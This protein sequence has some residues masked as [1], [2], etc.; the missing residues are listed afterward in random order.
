MHKN[1]VVR[2]LLVGFLFLPTLA[3]HA[4]IFAHHDHPVC[5]ESNVHFH[6]IDTT[7]ELSDYVLE[8]N[9][10]PFLMLLTLAPLPFRSSL[11]HLH[12]S[13]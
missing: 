7:C 11:T 3:Q 6:A 4:H 5:D 12:K 13:F 10:L 2:F 1:I 9:S 8:L